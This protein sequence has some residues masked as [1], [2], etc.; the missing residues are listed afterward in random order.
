MT[1]RAG[2]DKTGGPEGCRQVRYDERAACKMGRWAVTPA[3][4]VSPQIKP[5]LTHSQALAWSAPG[6]ADGGNG[7]CMQSIQS[8]LP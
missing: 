4:A 5:Y 2:A 1:A 8:G 3:P 6:V 7:I